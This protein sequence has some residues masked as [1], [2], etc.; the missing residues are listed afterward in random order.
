MSIIK[1]EKTEKSAYALEFS[2]DKATFDSAINKVYRQQVKNINI[3]GFRKGKA[4]RSIVERMYGKGV[5]Y[6]DAA[7]ELLPA[8]YEAALEESKVE[9]VGRAEFD[10][11]SIDENGI[12]FSAVVPVKPAVE[13]EGYKGIEAAKDVVEVSEVEIDNEIKVI[14]ERNSRETDVEDETP[15]AMGDSVKI[16]FEGFVDGVAFE[17][18]KGEDYN[19]KLGSGSFIPG[20][21]EQVADHK[22]GEAFDVNVTFPEDYHA[23]ELAGKAATFKVTVKAITKIELPELD[24]DFAKD[25]SEFDTMAEY[26]A[27]IEAKIRKRHEDA[28]ES[29]FEEAIIKALT[30]KLAGEEIP[31]A[32]FEAEQENQLRDFDNRLRMQGLDL[33][34]Y[35]KYTGLDLDKMRAQFRPQAESFVKVR[36]ALEKVAELENIEVTEEEIEAEYSRLA[37][38]YKM[39]AEQIKSMIPADSLTADLKVK[40]AMELVKANAVAP[41]KAD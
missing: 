21:E 23:A 14:R 2:V 24:D 39:E 40:K 15:A 37:E 33:Q 18:G 36:L 7:N 10:I 5:F 12:V 20:F 9:P 3:P 28:A 31:E 35:F 26:R 6:E 13:I 4:P 32:M 34:T 11:V 22:I 19:L 38:N 25:V 29:T 30:E 1:C 41:A 17:G 27:D 16:D 8:A